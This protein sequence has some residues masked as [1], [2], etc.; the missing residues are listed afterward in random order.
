MAVHSTT[1]TM[2][3]SLDHNEKGSFSLLEKKKKEKK[4]LFSFAVRELPR[5]PWTAWEQ[6]KEMAT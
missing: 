1:N 5:I 3:L 4:K 2:L 6:E